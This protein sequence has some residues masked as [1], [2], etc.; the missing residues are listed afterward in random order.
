MSHFKYFLN[1]ETIVQTNYHLYYLYQNK[2]YLKQIKIIN[3]IKM[4]HRMTITLN[5]LSF[6]RIF[7]Q[8]KNNTRFF[9][10]TTYNTVYSLK[11]LYSNDLYNF[12]FYLL[13]IPFHFIFKKLY[14]K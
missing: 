5:Y 8:I 2:I 3:L 7:K 1:L 9:V 13:K 10:I 11:L 4:Y 12:V 6:K 14:C